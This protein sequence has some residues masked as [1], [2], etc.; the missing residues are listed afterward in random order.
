MVQRTKYIYHN[1][2][3]PPNNG[4]SRA[5]FFTLSSDFICGVEVICRIRSMDLHTF[6]L[7]FKLLD[8]RIAYFWVIYENN[9]LNHQMLSFHQFEWLE[10]THTKSIFRLYFKFWFL[11]NASQCQNTVSTT[12]WINQLMRERER[13]II[14]SNCFR[15][16]N[17]SIRECWCWNSLSGLWTHEWYCW[18]I[19]AKTLLYMNFH[20]LHRVTIFPLTIIT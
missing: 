18:N 20:M 11:K 16:F 9:T 3:K 14:T 15:N 10:E 4:I 1:T 7:K 5:T 12:L 6:R 19:F 2:V 13:F 8:S 17:D